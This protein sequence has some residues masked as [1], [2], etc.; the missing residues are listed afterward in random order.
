MLFTS[1]AALALL[2]RVTELDNER[3]RVRLWLP[4]L[5]GR[6]FFGHAAS[7]SVVHDEVRPSELNAR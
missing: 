1:E 2:E 6:R 3:P 5:K 4:R 7:E